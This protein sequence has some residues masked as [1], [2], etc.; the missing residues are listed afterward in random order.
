MKIPLMFFFVRQIYTHA[1]RQHKA[2]SHIRK[3]NAPS[4]KIPPQCGNKV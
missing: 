3:W 2:D 1:E 4:V